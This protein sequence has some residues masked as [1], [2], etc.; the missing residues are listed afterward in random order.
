MTQARTLLS[1]A[2]ALVLAAPASAQVSGFA[3]VNNS[4]GAMSALAIRRVGSD[5]WRELNVAAGA[6]AKARALFDDPDCAF[7]LRATV[8]AAGPTMWTGVNLCGV[9]S[10][11]LNRDSAGRAWVD[12][13]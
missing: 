7:D 9:K 1:I 13:E 3:F 8:A 11:T 12:Y 4:G 2:A 10:L 5:E 6:G